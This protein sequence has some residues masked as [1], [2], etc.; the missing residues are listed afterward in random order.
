M[1]SFPNHYRYGRYVYKNIDIYSHSQ[2]FRNL[3]M[4]CSFYM[5]TFS[6]RINAVTQPRRGIGIH[7]H[8]PAEHGSGEVEGRARTGF[9]FV[10]ALRLQ[11]NPGHLQEP[12]G[13]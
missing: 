1:F 8:V 2:T 11:S 3:L 7:L 12:A 4:Q 5:Q 6:G 9:W 10:P 13:N